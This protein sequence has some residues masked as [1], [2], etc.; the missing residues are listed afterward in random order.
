M[1]ARIEHIGNSTL[2]LA[3]C[4]DILPTLRG[5]GAVITSPPYNMGVIAGGAGFSNTFRRRRGHYDPNG[6]YRKRGG[7]KKWKGGEL[8]NG[9]GAHDDKLPWVDYEIWQRE[10][11]AL[12]WLALTDDGAIFYN[13]KPRPALEEIW[14]PTSLNPGFPLRQI[15]IWA[16]AGGINFN[17]THYMPTHEWVLVIARP[18]FRLR[19]KA[20]SGVGDVWYIPQEGT[21]NHPAPF[22]VELPSRILE[23]ISAVK[24]L[25]PFM[26]SGST[27]VA[28]V[29]AGREFIGIEVEPRWFDLAC[30]RID[31][32]TRQPDLFVN[33]IKPLQESMPV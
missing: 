33:Q 17:A 29:R 25:D 3:D 24:V 26:G 30:R 13:H 23:T 14:L 12:C 20:A 7:A 15:I 21:T 11:L 6:G 32:A 1:T 19:D 18:K 31:E 4:R 8:A 16:R 9:Y 28:C 5:I 22:P 2:Y 27:G 10:V